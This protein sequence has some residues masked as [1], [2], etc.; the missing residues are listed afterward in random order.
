MKQTLSIIAVIFC[1]VVSAQKVDTI[2]SAI[3][4][5]PVVVN[6][7][8]KDTAY[9]LSWKAND[10]TRDT[11]LPVA[12]YIAMYSRGGNKIS[13][14]NLTIPASVIQQWGTSDTIIDDYIL[15]LYNLKKKN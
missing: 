15:K 11:S 12:F 4:I 10:L 7:M 3:Q 8:T 1:T 14:F 5:Q 2:K 13:D 6:A 9:Q